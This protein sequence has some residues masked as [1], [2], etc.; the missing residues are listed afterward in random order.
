MGNWLVSFEDV[1]DAPLLPTNPRAELAE[2]AK[3]VLFQVPS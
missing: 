3:Q 2:D 1:L